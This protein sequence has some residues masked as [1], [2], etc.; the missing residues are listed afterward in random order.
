VLERLDLAEPHVDG[1]AAIEA[2][3][4]FRLRRARAAAA[5]EHVLGEVREPVELADARIGAGQ[6][7]VHCLSFR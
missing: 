5:G 6:G 2:Q 4:H 3:A 1:D 7:C